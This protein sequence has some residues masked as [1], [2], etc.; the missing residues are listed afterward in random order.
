MTST[1][2]N[3]GNRLVRGDN[4]HIG[5]ANILDSAHEGNQVA[6]PLTAAIE[7]F[8]LAQNE[9]VSEHEIIKFCERENLFEKIFSEDSNAYMLDL[10]TKHFLVM[11][12]LYF[13]RDQFYKDGIGDLYIS[14]TRIELSD[15]GFAS[16]SQEDKEKTSLNLQSESTA[17]R[18]YYLDMDNLKGESEHSINELLGS[19]WKKY[20]HYV[21]SEEGAKALA[22]FELQLPCSLK[23]LRV[24]YK[25]K[26]H[27]AHPDR[28]GNAQ[29]FN[30]LQLAYD[31]A[32]NFL[33]N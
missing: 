25:R 5:L 15:L 13:L 11:N 16:P 23:E 26:I 27:N 24:A 31:T 7:R 18:D 1:N 28:G 21:G 12:A 17:L 14:A 9:G 32:K 2:K 3:S 19:F 22:V 29:D 10:F 33:Q 20:A 8:M 30:E 6:N 4:D